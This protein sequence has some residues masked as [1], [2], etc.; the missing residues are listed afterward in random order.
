MSSGR[1]NESTINLRRFIEKKIL[2]LKEFTS[3]ELG[4]SFL[5]E[6]LKKS[7]D[8][9]TWNEGNNAMAKT[10]QFLHQLQKDGKV[11]IV[12]TELARNGKNRTIW[13]VINNS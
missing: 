12:R 10:R 4:S 7:R 1:L 6:H 9:R 13:A 3:Y 5:D 11:K 2:T 8:R